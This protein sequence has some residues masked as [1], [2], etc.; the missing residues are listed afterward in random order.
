[1][2][3][4]H[5]PTPHD[6]FSAAILTWEGTLEDDPND[7]GN[8]AHGWDGS[9]RLV[10]TMRGVT[11]D[12]YASYL[13][14]DPATLTAA[15]MQ[16]EISADVAANIELRLYYVDPGFSI[17][18]WSPL[19]AAAVDLGWG[20]GPMLAIRV[21]QSLAGAMVDGV[22]GPQTRHAVDAYVEANDIAAA[23]DA[24]ADKRAAF[25]R[26]ISQPGSQ[27]ARFRAGWLNR[28]NWFRPS[29]PA[30]WTAWAGWT[31]PVPVASS[32]LPAGMAVIDA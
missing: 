7:A 32:F 20:S 1:M 12:T 25:Y 18:T 6:S 9:V 4:P 17:L 3:A 13:K 5:W 21:L 29:N 15:R 2:T 11:P 23:C 22:I 28:A 8:Y 16:S 26:A 14:I 19:V 10:G 30:W 31:M 27:N 24:F